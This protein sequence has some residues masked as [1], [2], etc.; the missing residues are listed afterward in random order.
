MSF[1]TVLMIEIIEHL[2]ESDAVEL[3]AEA[4]RVARKRVVLSTP[5]YPD[6]RGG[7][8]D[9]TGWNDL[10]AHLS[11]LSQSRLRQLGFKISGAG[12]KSRNRYVRGALRRIGLLPWFD[13]RFRP[14]FG[15]LGSFIPFTAQN[16][17]A[18]WVRK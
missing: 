3:I 12:L 1:D 6:F 5:N 17:V 11:Y 10:D 7:H 18:V 4:K 14:A 2:P 9:I 16:T 13:A 15:C 8:D